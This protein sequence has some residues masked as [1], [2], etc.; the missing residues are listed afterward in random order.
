MSKETVKM[1]LHLTKETN[2]TLEKLRKASGSTS[3][4]ELLRKSLALM[5]LVVE[6][7]KK[8]NHLAIL[9][10]KDKKLSEIIGL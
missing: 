7:K 5:A 4:S 9:D 3:K 10:N 1:S 6:N 2:D 8:G